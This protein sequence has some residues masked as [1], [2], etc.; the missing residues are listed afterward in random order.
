M[1]NRPFLG[2]E[3][4]MDHVYDRRYSKEFS[5]LQKELVRHGRLLFVLGAIL[6]SLLTH[7]IHQL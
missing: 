7:V 3:R 2:E 1:H 6:G 4:W 5:L